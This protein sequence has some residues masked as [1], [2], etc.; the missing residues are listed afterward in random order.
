MSRFTALLCLAFFAILHLPNHVL[1]D[2]IL[3]S[4]DQYTLSTSNIAANSVRLNWTGAAATS[5]DV[6]WRKQGDN[7]WVTTSEIKANSFLLT[8][9]D[10]GQSYEWQLLPAGATAWLG[11]PASFT[12]I[13]SC[14]QPYLFGTYDLLSTGVRI[15]WSSTSSANSVIVEIRLSG[16][17][18]WTMAATLP[19]SEVYYSNTYTFTGLSPATTYECRI[20]QRCSPYSNV[21]T[22]TTPKC[23]PTDLTSYA[24]PTQSQLSWKRGTYQVATLLWRQQGGNWTTVQ[25]LYG[26][27][28]LYNLTPNTGYDWQ[29]QWECGNTV[30]QSAIQSFTTVC[31][32][33]TSVSIKATAAKQITLGWE[34]P[35]PPYGGAGTS[36]QVRYRLQSPANSPWSEPTPI[37]SSQQYPATSTQAYGT[38]YS[39]SPQTGYDLQLQTTCPNST[40]SPFTNPPVSATTSACVN[41][42]RNL[43]VGSVGWTGA[44]L[45][46]SGDN[47][48]YYAT[49]YRVAGTSSWSQVGPG[50]YTGNSS[51]SLSGL[52]EGTTYE[53]RV[54]TYC[55]TSLS[56]ATPSSI[57]TFTTLACQTNLITSTNAYNV[58]YTSATLSWNEY[59]PQAGQ[60]SV[61]YRLA[62]SNTYTVL[63]LTT[64]YSISLTGLAG[65]TAYEWQVA[66]VCSASATSFSYSAP[67]TFTTNCSQKAQGLSIANRITSVDLSWYQSDY[68]Y[69]VPTTYQVRYR[70]TGGSWATEAVTTTNY[71]VRLSLT[72]LTLNTAYDWE[73][74]R[75]CAAGV[76]SAYTAGTSFTTSCQS[77]LYSIQTQYVTA[78]K[79]TLSF[80]FQTY[81]PS[82]QLRYRPVG[83][84]NWNV[85]TITNSYYTLTGLLAYTNYEWQVAPICEGTYLG[86]F[87]PIQTFTTNCYVPANLRSYVNETLAQLIW[88]YNPNVAGYNLQYRPQGSSNWTTVGVGASSSQYNWSGAPG[89]Y[90]WRIQADC[91]NGLTSDYSP[92]QSFSTSCNRPNNL[93]INDLNSYGATAVWTSGNQVI[94]SPYTLQW[95]QAGTS[96]WTTVTDLAQ[97]SYTFAGLTSGTV[98]ETRVLA[99]CGTTQSAYSDSR[100]FGA[101][102]STPTA[103]SST[104]T[105]YF[106]EPGRTFSWSL[107]PGIT[108]TVRWRRLAETGQPAPDWNVRAGLIGTLLVTQFLPGTYE[109]QVQSECVDGTKSAF[110]GGPPFVIPSCPNGLITQ[111]RSQVE[112][113]SATLTYSAGF[114]TELRWRRAGAPAWNVASQLMSSSYS[115]TELA[116]NTGYEWQVRVLCPTGQPTEFGPVQRFTTSCG[117]PTSLTLLCNM[118]NQAK[119]GWAGPAGSTYEVQWRQSGAPTWNTNLVNGTTAMLTS[120]TS[121]YSSYEWQVRPACSP[122]SS[123]VYSGGPSFYPQCSS[124]TGLTLIRSN[125]CNYTLSWQHGCAG[126][127]SY[128]VRL[129]YNGGAWT[130]YWFT[131]STSFY[132]G[133]LTSG[134]YVEAEVGTVCPGGDS[135]TVYYSNTVSLCPPPT[136]SNLSASVDGTKGY[137]NWQTTC[138]PSELRWRQ[139]G[140]AWTTVSLNNTFY[141]LEGLTLDAVYEWQVRSTCSSASGFG[142]TSFFRARCRQPFTEIYGVQAVA[143][144][145]RFYF[146]STSP[147]HEVRYRP[148]GSTAWAV[149]AAPSAPVYLVGLAANTQYEMQLRKLCAPGVWSDWSPSRYATTNCPAPSDLYASELTDN[150]A[151]LNWRYDVYSTSYVRTL[152]YR[153]SGS[154]SWITVSQGILKNQSAYSYTLTGL[155]P[156]TTYE[157]QVVYDCGSGGTSSLSDRPVTF[158]TTGVAGPCSQM[159]TVLPGSWDDPAT[160]SCG[161]VP[162]ATDAVTIRHVVQ[163]PPG[164]AAPVQRVIFG[165]DGQLRYGAGA[166]L[167]PR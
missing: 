53:W 96:A 101:V 15:S 55:T 120:L 28:T 141:Q 45:S 63:P 138:G 76:T 19:A 107:T 20:G 42:V 133:T 9:L 18:S 23:E 14:Y 50:T 127:V 91:V 70:P 106:T 89:V 48:V 117:Q 146:G 69:N 156:Q 112:N 21:L 84:A 93:T 109:W 4:A 75:V 103:L 7:L 122:Q 47:D 65:N 85:L 22:F 12:T 64:S 1:A 166:K 5:F 126:S 142:S 164:Q 80:G 72:G 140:G 163:M 16:T 35:Y 71:S 165:A 129:R 60:Y 33:P 83:T 52:Q 124:P 161:R 155:T 95:R 123:T 137:L 105:Y 160:W 143:D 46:W 98:Y 58:D 152:R 145:I 144:S 27:Y 110:V 74:A 67:N 61:R 78:V 136:I 66:P 34:S 54:V 147:D 153:P 26:S 79:A 97:S 25:N 108:Y 115:L 17:T 134:M 40:S 158:R 125:D 139:A 31:S 3:T 100:S 154:T 49:Q 41:T 59:Y 29:L 11:G 56:A 151:R 37:Y 118:G 36:T 8:D 92:I 62:G 87:S 102:C 44:S 24:T 94:N 6:R 130:G 10:A 111:H 167:W 32:P 114:V 77:R 30:A 90:E 157:W 73:V 99:Q 116:E 81:A 121:A 150:S 82:Y 104:S 135:Y 119:V 2:P 88:D 86:D 113:T 57:Q 148:V 13:Y 68:Q 39:L 162:L 128:A 51:V 43:Y 149:K 131:S 38:V 132:L 159:V